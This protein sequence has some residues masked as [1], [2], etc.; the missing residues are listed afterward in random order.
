MLYLST[1][2]HP[3]SQGPEPN[4][5]QNLTR[6]AQ[7]ALTIFKKNNENIPSYK[8]NGVLPTTGD[9]NIELKKPQANHASYPCDQIED[10]VRWLLN[11]AFSTIV[12][13][14]CAENKQASLRVPV[15]SVHVISYP[16]EQGVR[17][18]PKVKLSHDC[19]PT[20]QRL[21]WHLNSGH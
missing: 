19:F 21:V 12:T 8:Q 2:Q 11:Q 7:R 4:L 1:P 18:E 3:L 14:P 5:P 6:P 16:L 10:D 20:L 9:S 15:C 13:R 17:N